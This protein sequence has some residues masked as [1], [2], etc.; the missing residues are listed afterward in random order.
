MG[1]KI[2][3]TILYMNMI[4]QIHMISYEFVKN[5]VSYQVCIIIIKKLLKLAFKVF[6]VHN[7]KRSMEVFKIIINISDL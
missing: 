5:K 6:M 4:L 2:T 3:N 1:L 7:T